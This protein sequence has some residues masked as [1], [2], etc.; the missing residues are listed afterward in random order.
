M[1][2]AK[3]EGVLDQDADVDVLIDMMEGAAIQH[4]L[5]HPGPVDPTE[6]TAYLRRLLRQVGFRLREP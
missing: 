4:L 2:R 6:L 1:Q 5:M 3:A